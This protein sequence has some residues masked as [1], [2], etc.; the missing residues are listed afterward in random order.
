MNAY[1]PQ[2]ERAQQ[3][4][5]TITTMWPHLSPSELESLALMLDRSAMETI[6]QSLEDARNGD[7]ESLEDVV[8]NS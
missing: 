7:F 3:A 8:H 1:S 6:E 5:T 4:V 2:F